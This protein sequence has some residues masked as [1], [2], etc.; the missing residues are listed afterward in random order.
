MSHGQYRH[1]KFE[2]HTLTNKQSKR[3]KNLEKRKQG[4]F[5]QNA[6]M[7]QDLQSYLHKW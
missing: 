5:S 1:A 7:V 4:V 2:S 3:N 6:V